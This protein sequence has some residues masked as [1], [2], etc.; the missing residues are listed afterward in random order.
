MF[1]LHKVSVELFAMRNKQG[2][3]KGTEQQ[4]YKI[5]GVAQ[6][7][8]ASALGAE[9]RGFESHRPDPIPPFVASLKAAPDYANVPVVMDLCFIPLG[10]FA[11]SMRHTHRVNA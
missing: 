1:F 3:R 8:S 11:P 4:G 7:G 10:A 2:E 9:S 5:R 6:P